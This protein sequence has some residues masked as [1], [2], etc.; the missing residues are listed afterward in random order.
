MVN[1]SSF[2]AAFILTTAALASP[3]NRRQVTCVSGLYIISARGTLEDPGE[4]RVGNV[5]SLLKE[6]VPGM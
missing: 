1:V 6:E 5:S 4:G 2:L 3:V